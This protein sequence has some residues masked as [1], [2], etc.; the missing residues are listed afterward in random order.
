MSVTS[1]P[2]ADFPEFL[3]LGRFSTAQYLRMIELGV[4]GPP[5]RLASLSFLVGILFAV[6]NA[7]AEQPNPAW[8]ASPEAI[9]RAS[10]GKPTANFDEAKV[11]EF[12]LVDPLL[13]DVGRPI[14]QESW[15]QRRA[16]WIHLFEREMFGKAPVGRPQ[17]EAFRVVELDAHALA[18]RA[19]RKL[20]EISFDTPHAGRY[21]FPLQLFLP[22]EAQRPVPVLLLLQFEGLEDPA[23]PLVLERG[24]GLAI[25]DR[26]RLAADDP[27]TFRDGVINAFSTLSPAAPD[28]WQAI[29]A[30]A[31]GA[32]RALDYLAS[33]PDVDG[34]RV[35]VVGFSRMGK[36]ALWAGANDERF[37]A[38]ISNESGAGGAA[39]S[40]RRFGETIEDLNVRFPHWFAENYRQYNG[41][42][43]QLPFD[44]HQL[45][46]LIAPRPLYVGSADEDLW[47][48]P[49]GEFLSCV[50]ASPVYEL[51]G[52]S[53]LGTV[54]MPPLDTP[55]ATGHIGYHI[56][57]G[58]HAFTDYDWNRYLDFLDRHLAASESSVSK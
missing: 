28:A 42:E 8:S 1:T 45:L 7:A 5:T 21:S 30:W 18:G 23:T 17:N 15:G 20:V 50:A 29:A 55:I 43:G 48:D 6:V 2:S 12:K 3:P 38:V 24:W 58:R 49:R 51:L 19:T 56:R 35:A 27:T 31:W 37:A 57:R 25:L 53:G 52:V 47:S 32:S 26:T 10:I 4:L 44:Q 54:V 11:G 39:L 33:D 41:R 22:N 36:T 14:R 13:D 46:T 40:N 16:A 9:E 34:K